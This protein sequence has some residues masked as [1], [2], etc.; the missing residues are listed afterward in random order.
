MKKKFLCL[1]SV[2]TLGFSMTP[3]VYAATVDTAQEEREVST[4]SRIEAKFT[5][6][7][8]R[9]PV[10][11]SQDKLKNLLSI[12]FYDEKGNSLDMG[13]VQ[14]EIS[15]FDTSKKGE[16]KV[17]VSSCG[18]TTEFTVNLLPSK[19][20][21]LPTFPAQGAPEDV[22]VIPVNGHT[23]WPLKELL[24]NAD[25]PSEIIFGLGAGLVSLLEFFPNLDVSTAGFHEYTA[26]Y[27]IEYLGLETTVNA[28]ICIGDLSQLEKGEWVYTNGKWWYKHGDGSYTTNGWEY[29][30][31]YWY[32]FDD[33]GYMKTGWT[34]VNGSCYYL[35]SDGHMA[36]NETIDGY[37]VNSS[38]VWIP[39]E[40]VY[41]S[42]KWWYKHGDGS[43]T[44]NGWEY[45]DGYWYFFDASGYMKTGW[46]WVN[47]SCY[48]LYSDGHMASNET[49][50]GY[51]VNSSGVWIP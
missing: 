9:L 16:Q 14:Y 44:T 24:V 10:G 23:A 39:N 46:T 7:N 6:L 30:D 33:Y 21:I 50:D 17:T 12:K 5:T 36:C 2:F 11:I 3:N 49:I 40:W 38:G 51:Y 25:N 19:V 32:F 35:Y 45:I 31:G 4:P 1:L 27:Y 42:G 15:P 47:G 43:Y 20:V 29:I 28:K 8:N 48:Y 34:W 26:P 18:L 22:F 41:T 13:E 37:Y